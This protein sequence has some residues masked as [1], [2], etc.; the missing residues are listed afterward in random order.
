MSPRPRAP[1]VIGALV[2]TLAACSGGSAA[3]TTSAGVTT[4]S[5][6]PVT[7]STTAAT[8]CPD[9]FCVIY[10][11]RPEATWSDGAPVGAADFAHTLEVIGSQA[12][13]VGNPGYGLI[14]GSR[15]VDDKTFMI[16]MS[17]VFA[18]WRTL[19]EMVLPAHTEYD[20]RSPGP[21]S[22][23]FALSEWIEGDHILL[24]RNPHHTPLPGM[25]QG[26]VEQLRFVVPVSART[27]ISDLE[28]GAVDVIN[29]RP[30]DW[31]I[32]DLSEIE[33]VVYRV[34][35]GP[36]WEHIDFH[37]DDPLLTQSWVRRS[38]AL[39]LDREAIL[40]ATVRTI[41]PAA[42]VLGNTVWMQESPYYQDHPT[43]GYDPASAEQ[44]LIE[45]FCTMG[46]DDV[47]SCQGRRM[48]FVW[49]TTAGD[50]HREAQVELAVEQL[51]AIGI[52]VVPRLSTPSDLFSEQVLFGGPGA[53]QII[54]FSWKAAAD[55]F[56][57]DS[58]YR[59][60]GDGPHGMGALNVNRFC[61][62][63]VD[64]LIA[65]TRPVLDV[66]ER[67]ALYNQADTIYLE[68]LAVIPLYQKPAL[69]AW[70]SGLDGLEPNPWAT[71]L[72]NAGSWSGRQTVVVALESEPDTLAPLVPVND[73]VAMVR[74]AMY[75]GAFGVTPGLEYV[76]VLVS[77]AE[78]VVEGG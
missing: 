49:A 24:T 48:S 8:S 4:S 34:V 51:G 74:S 38:I 78:T 26:D 68:N 28:A 17:E 16:A 21:V 7:T 46:D 42:G 2:L 10:H 13:D 77:E 76:P 69:L 62:E 58:T 71:D 9:R 66:E 30:L 15:V 72:W 50:E 31:M 23:P 19:F 67:S 36:F 25:T 27:M 75:L 44:I 40:D 35:P 33:G 60:V 52:E 59:C 43:P 70:S 32:E 12:T 55:P 73:S 45:N 39:A 41:D 37:H 61:R 64:E 14:S 65:A 3:T 22:G 56:L 11:I 6:P 47:Y 29:P 5:S 20:P 54:S 63:E 53:W 57:G 18:P 1:S